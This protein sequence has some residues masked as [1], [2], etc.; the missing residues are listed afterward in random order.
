[1]GTRL[2][3]GGKREAGR[4]RGAPAGLSL[5]QSRLHMRPTRAGVRMPRVAG[6]QQGAGAAGQPRADV[7]R[8]GARGCSR[9]PMVP[10]TGWRDDLAMIAVVIAIMI[11]TIVVTIPIVRVTDAGVL[12]FPVALE[13]LAIF[14]TRTDPARSGVRSPCPVALVPD[15]AVVH[16][17]PVAIHPGVAGAWSHRANRDH[18]RRRW[19]PNPDSHGNLRKCGSAQQEHR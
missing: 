12:A 19:R 2:A 3:E 18:A 14:M 15:I 6:A 10:R 11:A 4:R 16:G 13:P 9:A 17:I 5:L 1:M 7:H 8:S